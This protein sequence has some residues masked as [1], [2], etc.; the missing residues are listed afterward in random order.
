MKRQL[1]RFLSLFMMICL[2]TGNVTGVLAEEE[3][4]ELVLEEWELVEEEDEESVFVIDADPAEAAEDLENWEVDESINPEDLELNTELSDDVVNILL[5]G[6]DT[7]SRDL[8]PSKGLQH[9]DVTMVCSINT[10]EG[11]VKLS[12][13][14]R[15]LYVT[16]PGYKNKSR[17]NNAYSRG[18]GELAMRTVN[19]NFKLNIQ[20]YVTIN[21]YGLASIIDAIGGIDIDLS[22][23]EA[24]AIN[25]YLRKHPPAYDNTD[26]KSRTPLE[27]KE[28][29]QH[30]DGVQAVMYARLREIDNDFKRTARQRHLLELLLKKVLEDISMNNLTNLINTSKDYVTTNMNP[31]TLLNLALSVLKGD[32]IQ[33]MKSGGEVISQHRIPMDKTY[34]YATIDGAS[35]INLS[36]KNWDINVNALHSFIY[37]N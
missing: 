14:L 7:R 18:G 9:N 23:T 22:K 33:N 32:I 29:I 8:D 15:D 2:L 4:E 31:G 10:A 34:S 26:G 17:I 30:L 27:R 12:S 37:V 16:I 6:I 5:V 20:H 11:T 1:F 19:H 25:T 28:G 36:T 21:F 35:V 13:I 3:E 24:G